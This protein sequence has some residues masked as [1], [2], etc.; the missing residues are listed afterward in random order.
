M[1]ILTFKQAERSHVHSMFVSLNL[2]TWHSSLFSQNQSKK[3]QIR[4]NETSP[5]RLEEVV[6]W[7]VYSSTFL[8][9]KTIQE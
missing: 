3:Y 6:D 1:F 7:R 9:N 8:S 4:V 5:A 2:Q